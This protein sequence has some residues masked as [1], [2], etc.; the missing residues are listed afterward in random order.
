[1][2]VT[3]PRH[4]ALTAVVIAVLTIVSVGGGQQVA[5]CSCA[6]IGM[7]EAIAGAD[8][9]FIGTTS[10]RI[11]A[12]D[13]AERYEWEFTVDEVITGD[14]P[15]EVTVIGSDWRGGCGQDYGRTGEPVLVL[16]VRRGDEL[17]DPGSAPQLD[18]D[19][20]TQALAPLPAPD[21]AGPVGA[22]AVLSYRWA[23]VAALDHRGRVLS[24]GNLPGTPT[25]LGGCP[26]PAP[27]AV[28]SLAHDDGTTELALIDL[29]TMTVA[30]TLA[31][32]PHG[33]ATDIACIAVGGQPRPRVVVAGGGLE[34]DGQVDLRSI[35][36]GD[37]GWHR[38][39]DAADVSFGPDGSPLT[40]PTEAGSRIVRWSAQNGE[41]TAEL[42]LLPAEAAVA[43]TMSATGDRLAVLVTE[44]GRNATVNAVATAIVVVSITDD[45]LTREDV[46]AL[47]T[48]GVGRPAGLWFLDD[49]TLAIARATDSSTRLDVVA[50]DGTLI[51]RT[52]IG[53]TIRGTAVVLDGELVRAD[54][55]GLHAI[56]RMGTVKELIP[57]RV[58]PWWGLASITVVADG[59][60]IASV[61]PLPPVPH[62]PSDD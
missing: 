46:I 12:D 11:A 49:D 22:L 7:A 20:L 60:T 36:A 2:P 17:V 56:D 40:V 42:H 52:D 9:A 53:W 16:A 10:T 57:P 15:A 18:G 21:G 4:L 3:R 54:E 43:V 41:P 14:V 35:S 13:L 23:D 32:D 59:P 28:A 50:A 51:S 34:W 44:D 27:T 61:T 19:S 33:F 37:D 1:M 31:T 29:D 48:G 5:A 24:W 8:V 62:P 45:G 58:T 47:P 55:I 6:S 38:S 26:G 30:E 25:V 39:V